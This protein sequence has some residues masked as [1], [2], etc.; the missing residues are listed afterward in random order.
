MRREIHCLAAIL[1]LTCSGCAVFGG[2][3]PPDST[4]ENDRPQVAEA[5]AYT[6]PT[7]PPVN[8]ATLAPTTTQTPPPTPSPFTVFIVDTPTPESGPSTSI[9]TLDFNFEGWERYETTY[10]GIAF[11]TPIN[12]EIRDYG[13][14]IRIGDLDFSDGGIQLFVEVQVDNAASGYLP[15][16]VNPYDPRSVVNGILN[17]FEETYTDV[18][19][20]RPV[21]N[22]NMNGYPGADTAVRAQLTVGSGTVELIWYLAAVVHDETV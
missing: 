6:A 11:D 8:T 18:A 21:A 17:E 2:S 1:I 9:P 10:T 20:I 7:L 12:M 19:L 5:T 4:P 3:A 16:D 13:R 14:V 22:A 15:G